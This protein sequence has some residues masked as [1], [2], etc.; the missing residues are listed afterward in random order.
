MTR[1]ILSIL[2]AITMVIG[3]PFYRPKVKPLPPPLAPAVKT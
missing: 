1:K 2:L 3:F